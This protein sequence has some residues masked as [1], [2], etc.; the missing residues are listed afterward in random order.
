MLKRS[1]SR[2]AKTFRY[3][4]GFRPQADAWFGATRGLYN[5]VAAFFYGVLEAHPDVRKLSDQDALTRLEK[6]THATRA[7]PAP[8]HPLTQAIPEDLPAMFRRAAIHAALGSNR[9]FHS[10][11]ERWQAAKAAAEA[12]AKARKKPCA[13]HAR[14]PVPPRSWDKSPVLYAGMWRA[15]EGRTVL[16]N[17]WTGTSW[18]WTKFGVSGRALP[19]GWKLGSPHLVEHGRGWHLHV[20]VTRAKFRLPARAAEQLKDKHTRLCSVDLNINDGL[21]VCTI[22]G[23]DGA[24]VATRFI[25]GGRD[26]QRRRKRALGKVARHRSQTGRIQDYTTDNAGLF[27]YVRQIDEDTAHRVSRRIVEFAQAYG[28]TLIV[29]E[30]LGNFRPQKGKYSHRGNEKRSFWLRGR[31]FRYTQY[32]AWSERMLTCRVSPHNTSRLCAECGAEVA[33]YS[34]GEAPVDYRPGAPLMMCPNCLKRGNADRN[35]SLNIGRRLIQRT[36]SKSQCSSETLARDIGVAA[37]QGSTGKLKGAE[38]R[39]VA[40]RTRKQGKPSAAVSP[41]ARPSSNGADDRVGTAQEKPGQHLRP[42]RFT[43]PLRP[44]QSRGYATQTRGTAN[45]GEPEE[46][47]GL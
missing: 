1:A 24:A 30:H 10:N 42:G 19:K 22:L 18:A 9:S 20:P 35:A 13:F 28:A 11:L 32:K 29:F 27:R 6:L 43:R 36:I 38:T 2:P 34:Y 5:R 15:F 44:P 41:A 46:A 23:A 12:K 16:L 47:A 26:L 25:R 17:V 7:N 31:I 14:P 4:L 45:A 39:P 8:A 37:S 40:Q 3:H 33:R 21:A